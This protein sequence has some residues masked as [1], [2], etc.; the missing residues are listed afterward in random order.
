[1]QQ[2]LYCWFKFS[3]LGS[4]R[5]IAKALRGV[6]CKLKICC[7]WPLLSL[8]DW[9]CFLC[10]PSLPWPTARALS[11][12]DIQ[13][14]R[15]TF[16]LLAFS[17]TSVTLPLGFWMSS[18]ARSLCTHIGTGEPHSLRCVLASGCWPRHVDSCFCGGA[19]LWTGPLCCAS[20]RLKAVPQ[21]STVKSPA[22]PPYATDPDT[23]S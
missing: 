15:L 1:M 20:G 8:Q 22:T 12:R 21:W 23:A 14:L 13:S 4:P 9:V 2:R 16:L 3:D 19:R 17:R 7:L 10:C 5:G 11:Q 6:T 18:K